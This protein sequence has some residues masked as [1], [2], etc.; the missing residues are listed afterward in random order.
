M[1][2]VDLVSLITLHSV[3]FPFQELELVPTWSK[4]KA[5]MN[6]NAWNH[7]S[8][9][10]KLYL[11]SPHSLNA[12]N[13][14][15]KTFTALIT[16]QSGQLSVI[17]KLLSWDRKKHNTPLSK[18]WSKNV[19]MFAS[20]LQLSFVRLHRKNVYTLQRMRD[21]KL[22]FAVPATL[23][24]CATDCKNVRTILAELE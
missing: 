8:E 20:S 22:T 23:R 5:S 3:S 6:V 18:S 7:C 24:S 12:L 9:V 2:S 10:S 14:E 21:W 11:L 1:R 16:L 19:F 4:Q 15:A 13:S 17:A